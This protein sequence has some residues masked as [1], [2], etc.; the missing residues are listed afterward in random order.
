MNAKSLKIELKHRA[1]AYAQEREI[2]VDSSP[3][4]ATIFKN[5]SDNFSSASS[6]AIEQREEWRDR[7]NKGHTQVPGAL[8]MQSSNSSDALL[9][10]IFCYPKILKW[11]G[12]RDLLGVDENSPHFG[13]SPLVEKDGTR[14]ESTEIDMEI[15]DLFVEAKLTEADFVS[16]DIAKVSKY[17]HLATYFHIEQ[18][19]SDGKKFTT[20]Q[21]IR[22]LLAAIQHGKRHALFCDERRPDLVRSYFETVCCLKKAEHRSQCQVIFWQEIARRCGRDLAD[23]L[24]QKYGI[25]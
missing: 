1:E 6:Q 20:Y 24:R 2:A 22:N 3:K 25:Y 4:S 17:T 13:V 10:N 19:P 9:M 7:L 14:K 12:V 8:E 21:I 23:F 15:G 18:L 11:K 16:K 5:L